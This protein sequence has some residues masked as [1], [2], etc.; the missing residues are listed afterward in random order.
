MRQQ[1]RRAEQAIVNTWTGPWRVVS[2]ADRQYVV[3]VEDIATGEH[4]EVYVAW[5]SPYADEWLAVTAELLE[6]LTTL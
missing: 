1:A 2:V 4:K 3:G 5:M 6:V